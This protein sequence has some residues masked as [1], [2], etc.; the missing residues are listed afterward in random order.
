VTVQRQCVWKTGLGQSPTNYYHLRIGCLFVGP[1][2]VTLVKSWNRPI[3]EEWL[4]K[5]SL[6]PGRLDL[7]APAFSENP[8]NVVEQAFRTDVIVYSRYTSLR[9]GKAL[10]QGRRECT[11]RIFHGSRPDISL[12]ARRGRRYA[13]VLAFQCVWK[14]ALEAASVTAIFSTITG[15]RKLRLTFSWSHQL[16][17]STTLSVSVLEIQPGAMRELH[18]HPHADEWQYY[19]EGAAE[20]AVYLGMGHAVTEHFVAGDIGYVPMGA[21]HYIRNTGS[22]ILRLLIGFNN[23]HY[24]SHDLSAW[25]AS[26]PPDVSA[27]NLGLP[28]TVAEALPKETLF[29]ARSPP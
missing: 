2:G 8:L 27:A 9:C 19:L 22:G 3:L 6:Y 5:S 15:K 24:H 13:T 11:D 7:S 1:F 20:M 10:H 25:V 28:P 18:W 14:R 23:G 29:I 21:G 26:N 17:V 16:W 12:G 4:A